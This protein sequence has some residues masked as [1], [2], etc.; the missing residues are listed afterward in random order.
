MTT[1]LSWRVNYNVLM[2]ITWGVHRLKRLHKWF[3]VVEKKNQRIWEFSLV[4]YHDLSKNDLITF[5]CTKA[6]NRM[7][8][9]WYG[10][11]KN[12]KQT[13]P[14]VEAWCYLK[15]FSCHNPCKIM[16]IKIPS[17]F[18]DLFICL[19]TS[20]YLYTIFLLGPFHLSINK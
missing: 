5:L 19:L 3:F 11:N 13:I 20:M 12:E 14:L 17:F 6:A 7:D 8:A 2:R 4:L 1:S 16:L 9:F 18:S 15:L 10:N